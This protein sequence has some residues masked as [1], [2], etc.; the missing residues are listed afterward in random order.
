MTTSAG[1]STG[2]D[3]AGVPHVSVDVMNTGGKLE[4]VEQDV[5]VLAATV[6]EPTGGVPWGRGRRPAKL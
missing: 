2:A 6:R 4:S 1:G 5:I 3:G